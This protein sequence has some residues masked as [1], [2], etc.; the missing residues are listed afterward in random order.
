MKAAIP[1]RGSFIGSGWAGSG[2]LIAAALALDLANAPWHWAVPWQVAAALALAGLGLIGWT[3]ARMRAL[4]ASLRESEARYRLLAD[5][6]TDIIMSTD[7]EGTIRFA[8]PSVLQLGQF[9]P[10]ALIGRAALRLVAPQHRRRVMEAYARALAAGGQSVPVEFI[11]LPALTAPR[12]FDTNMRAVIGDDGRAECVVSVTR[13]MAERKEHETALAL[14]ALTDPLTG[15]PNRRLF[16]DA[17]EECI[18]S[19]KVACVAIFDLDHFKT[20]N[21]RY[22]H[23]A[24][25][26]VL[27][28]FA[29][30]ARQTLR[31][32]DTVARIGGEEFAL[33]LP[34]AGLDVSEMIC[35]RL[36][37]AL[38][39]AVTHFG[40]DQI[41]ITTSI[42]LARLG[43]NAAATLHKADGALYAAKAAGRDRLS[44]AA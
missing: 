19:Q 11:G 23:A 17:M 38:G 29:A 5:H 35:A 6:S 44:I 40:T 21:D 25:D 9:Q 10:D 41:A 14:A 22:G 4:L 13:D 15:L 12:W 26:A 2:Y 30:V 37:A 36:G 20:I 3:M 16:M 31:D 18:R 7:I 43:Q 1:L 34:G 42:G 33:L 8:S 39:Q 24:G 27:K 28:T 32:S